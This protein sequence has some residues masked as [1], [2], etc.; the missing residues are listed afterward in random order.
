MRRNQLWPA[1]LYV[2]A[3]S[4]SESSSEEFFCYV[5]LKLYE[6]ETISVVL[7]SA[8]A[9]FEGSFSPDEFGFL[10]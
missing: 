4:P 10:F 8:F 3:R 7:T 6:D 1:I 2:Q 9:W 5:H